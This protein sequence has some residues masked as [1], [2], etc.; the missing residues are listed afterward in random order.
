MAM[1]LPTR[2]IRIRGELANRVEELAA[3]EERSASSMLSWL[4]RKA[5]EREGKLTENPV[6]SG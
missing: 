4:V 6:T 5:L 1:K 2:T 3:A